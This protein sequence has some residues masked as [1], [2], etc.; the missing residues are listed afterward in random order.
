[1]TN[2]TEHVDLA[3]IDKFMKSYHE[4]VFVSS[5][6]VLAYSGT[7]TGFCFCRTGAGAVW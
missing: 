1:M 2:S 6:Q 3:S 7:G 4:P 5:V